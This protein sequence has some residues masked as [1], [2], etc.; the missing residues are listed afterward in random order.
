[1]GIHV[2]QSFIKGLIGLI[3]LLHYSVEEP[4]LRVKVAYLSKK[5][6]AAKADFA[7]ADEARR[8]LA[9]RDR[10]AA[11]V[12]ADMHRDMAGHVV[13][14]CPKRNPSA[15]SKTP[16]LCNGNIVLVSLSMQLLASR[17]LLHAMDHEHHV[18]TA[19]RAWHVR[20]C[21]VC[22]AS[23]GDLSTKRWTR[24]GQLCTVTHSLCIIW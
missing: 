19:A 9:Q 10:E 14:C 17:A 24:E 4:V 23:G 2:A 11:A 5:L 8:A 1:M 20:G 18:H 21:C 22:A 7:A 12:M 15:C 6:Q 3:S 13:R 16:K